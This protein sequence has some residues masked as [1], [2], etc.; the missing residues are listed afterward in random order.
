MCAYVAYVVVELLAIWEFSLNKRCKAYLGLVLPPD[1]RNW[2]LISSHSN[3]TF[4]CHFL[5][6]KNVS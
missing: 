5:L 4:M 2:Q 1:S 6:E 3:S